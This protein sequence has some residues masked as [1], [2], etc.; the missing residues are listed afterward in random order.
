[1]E[2]ERVAFILRSM[3]EDRGVLI[4]ANAFMRRGVDPVAYSM[5]H[6]QPPWASITELIRGY[7]GSETRAGQGLRNAAFANQDDVLRAWF[8]GPEVVFAPDG[9][10]LTRTAQQ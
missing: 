2:R 4:E 6:P 10:I 5:P 7:L 9:R 8:K 1:M 3:L